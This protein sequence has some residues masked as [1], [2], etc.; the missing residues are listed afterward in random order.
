MATTAK[1]SLVSFR[2][3][4]SLNSSEVN[5][6]SLIIAATILWLVWTSASSYFRTRGRDRL[7]PGSFGFPIIGDTVHFILATTSDVGYLKWLQSKI[8]KYGPFFKWRFQGKPVVMMDAPGGNKFLFQKEGTLL[9]IYWP[10]Q[11]ASLLGSD[12]IVLQLGE[13]HKL[14]RRYFSRFFDHASI[15]RYLEG[16]NR[17]AVQHFARHWG[18]NEESE[19]ELVPFDVTSLYTFSDICNL[20]MSLDEGPQLAS[21]LKD[22]MQWQNGLLSLPINLPGFTYYKAL[23]ARKRILQILEEYVKQRKREVAEG[24]VS[25]RAKVDILT[26]LLTVPNENGEFLSESSVC[27]NLLAFL[28]AG[29][30]TSSSALAMTIHLIGK[31]PDVYEQLVQEHKS[32]L[33]RKR[34]EGKDDVLTMEDL[35]AMRYTWQVIQ[36][37]L[38]MQPPVGAVFRQTIVDCEHNGYLIPK[39]WKLM[40]NTVSSH[41]DPKCFKDP[42][43]FNPSRWEQPPVPF[44]YIPFGGGQRTCLGNEFAKMQMLVFVHHFIRG[45]RWSVTDPNETV[46]R[47]PAPRTQKTIKVRKVT[48]SI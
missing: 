3:G 15:G 27:D 19:F 24:R 40:Y 4:L 29:F 23:K 17:N 41:Y 43:T 48:T 31:N 34:E 38:R 21:F 8:A 46:I 35:S 25:E 30:G 10:V 2:N 45:Y 1:D 37:T 6:T 39:D 42:M 18:N 13:R 47:D 12:S 7:P 9:E 44:A 32:I 33:D 36:E 5:Y 14:L 22:F 20:L 26:N 11:M 28:F 16:V